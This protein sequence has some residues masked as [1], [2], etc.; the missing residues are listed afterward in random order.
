MAGKRCAVVLSLG[1]RVDY[2]ALHQGW[3]ACYQL[4]ST[5]DCSF[6]LPDIVGKVGIVLVPHT[7]LI[8]EYSVD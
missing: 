8:I 2:E 7:L 1:S 3:H 6:V 4:G 5:L